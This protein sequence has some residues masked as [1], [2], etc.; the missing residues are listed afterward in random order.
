MYAIG[1]RYGRGRTKQR[2]P[3][4]SFPRVCWQE[5]GQHKTAYLLYER[6][7]QAV[8]K[9]TNGRERTLNA[10]RIAHVETKKKE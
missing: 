3:L 1:T 9:F 2:R 6:D 5:N 4:S 10:E 7:G 8:V